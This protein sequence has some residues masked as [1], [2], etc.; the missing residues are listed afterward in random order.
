LLRQTVRL[1]TR[2]VTREATQVIEAITITTLGIPIIRHTRLISR[3][4]QIR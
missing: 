3:F 2:V 1:I 4:I